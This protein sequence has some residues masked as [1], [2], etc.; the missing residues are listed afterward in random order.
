[1]STTSWIS[2]PSAVASRTA[3]TG[4]VF[5]YISDNQVSLQILNDLV[6]NTLRFSMADPA[7]SMQPRIYESDLLDQSAKLRRLT[8]SL[9]GTVVHPRI[10]EY[11]LLDQSAE[12][13]RLTDSMDWTVVHVHRR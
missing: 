7:Y 10:Y 2:Q 11:D 3:G 1:M 8:D 6:L 9:D 13:R 5:T 4:Q 12:L